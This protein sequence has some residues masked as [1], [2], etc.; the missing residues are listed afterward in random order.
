MPLRAQ[1]LDPTVADNPFLF[2]AKRRDLET[3]LV[4]YGRRYYSPGQGRFLGRDP[5][6][7]KGGRNLYAFCLNDS[8]NKWD[9]NGELF[10]WLKSIFVDGGGGASSGGLW[11]SVANFFGF[12]NSASGGNGSNLAGVSLGSVSAGAVSNTGAADVIFGGSSSTANIPALGPAAPTKSAAQPGSLEVFVGLDGDLVG[13]L[14]V[15][16]AGGIVINLDK[17]SQ[18]GIY[19]S[20]GPAAGANVG[21]SVNAGFALRGVSGLSGNIDVNAG[22]VSP[23]VSFD[24]DGFNGLAIGYGPGAGLSVSAT[25]TGKYTLSDFGA[26]LKNVWNRLREGSGPEP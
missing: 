17:L 19:G 13:I 2:Q 22:A 10:D 6:E 20:I 9:V 7:E 8:I 16:G 18:S 14:G 11:N 21:I 3:G 23:T 1:T 26:D 5:I 25:N 12:G 24:T 15:E 4:Y